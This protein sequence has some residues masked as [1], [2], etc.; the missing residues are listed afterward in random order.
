M[1]IQ[2]PTV[3]VVL[4][5]VLLSAYTGFL[6]GCQRGT[7]CPEINTSPKTAASPD[8][9]LMA[10]IE[11]DPKSGIPRLWCLFKGETVLDA[12]PL[13]LKLNR[14]DYDFTS[15]LEYIDSSSRLIDETYSMPVGKQRNR[16]NHCTETVYRFRNVSG[17]P[18]SIVVRVFDDGLAYRYRV[19][20]VHSSSV[21]EEIS[22]FSASNIANIW[23]IP[24]SSGDERVFTK[25]TSADTL[26]DK[27]LSF[28]VLAESKQGNW[29]L[30]TEADVSDYPLSSGM[31]KGNR[32]S[33][34]F[35]RAKEGTNTVPTSFQSPWRVMIFGDQLGAIVE[36]CMVDHLAPPAVQ[37]DLTW[38]EP[39]AS[40]FPWWGD[41]LANSDPEAIKK[42]IDLSAAMGWKYVEFDLA[43]IGSP[44][45]GRDKWK[46]TPWIKDVVDYGI[47]K[48]IRC[49]GWEEFKKLQTPQARAEIF[50]RYRDLEMAGCKVDFINS[51]SQPTR[52]ALEAI[53]QDAAEYE[54]MLSFHG[55]QSPRGFAR[56]YPYIMTYEGVKACEYYLPI[57]GGKGV[58]ASHNCVLPFTRNVLGSMDYTPVAFSSEVRKT[59][60]A[61]ELALS[62]VY[63][64][65]WQVFCDIPSMYLDSPARP[66]LYGIPASWDQTRLL[67]GYP[68]QLCCMARRKGADWY[69]AGISAGA[70][71][72]IELDL[73][74]LKKGKKTISLYHDKPGEADMLAITEIEISGDQPLTLNLK[75]NGGFAF[76]IGGEE[77]KPD[78]YTSPGL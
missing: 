5:G 26:Q 66:F 50:S 12:S 32:L 78:K 49:F 34:V 9:R 73:S 40:S 23:S 19:G 68:G 53:I 30:F 77:E 25:T 54:L 64:S 63:E 71:R 10:G 36:S 47:Q 37:Q 74:V 21:V 1:K 15:S 7:K 59:T 8:G 20:N 35:A 55:A 42:Y 2:H 14:G 48:G 52:R 24:F 13:G 69:V 46:T 56:T 65:G 29:M 6:G 58:P 38:V 45:R 67:S 43:L 3:A 75:K 41:N 33:Y 18:F 72:M 39:G 16:R 44:A 22:V 51:Y 62:V 28:P 17:I 76:M 61:H 27:P 4:M 11:T 60:M 31:F 70:P 57:N